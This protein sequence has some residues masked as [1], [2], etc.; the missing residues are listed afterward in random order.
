MRE[1]DKPTEATK[2]GEIP[3]AQDED[4][5]GERHNPA[6]PLPDDAGQESDYTGNEMEDAARQQTEYPGDETDEG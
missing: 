5:D 1:S 2:P 6:K 4:R 3:S